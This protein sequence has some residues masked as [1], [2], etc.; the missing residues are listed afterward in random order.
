[1]KIKISKDESLKFLNA[2]KV[3]NANVPILEMVHIKVENQKVYFQMTDLDNFYEFVIHEFFGDE[4][5]SCLVNKDSLNKFLANMQTSFYT[6]QVVGNKC[7]VISDTTIILPMGDMKDLI[8]F[9]VIQGDETSCFNFKE[10]QKAFKCSYA[11]S[12][13]DLRPTM[14]SVYIDKE[15]VIS[16]DA[17]K[18]TKVDGFFD[19]KFSFMINKSMSNFIKSYGYNG[20]ITMINGKDYVMIE[21]N[22]F[23]ILSRM[24]DGKYPDYKAVLPKE[25]VNLYIVNRELLIKT[26]KS[27][28]VGA[29][30]NS[31]M[32]I[33]SFR[34]KTMKVECSN[35]D[36]DIEC[37]AEIDFVN[38]KNVDITFGLNGKILI[39]ALNHLSTENVKFNIKAEMNPIM[40]NQDDN[41]S[42]LIMPVLV[43]K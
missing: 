14:Q 17:H 6:L 41:F 5:F 33:F 39:E 25:N 16:T 43:T 35:V 23:K 1:M 31:N 28:M 19:N 30:T 29:D 26:L 24:V 11:I 15:N 21:C 32:V 38:V 12:N 2:F 8:V 10:L 3:K 7:H 36:A 27:V 42:I 40:I 9:P 18:L 34:S 13:D 37:F 20:N 22:E 4:N